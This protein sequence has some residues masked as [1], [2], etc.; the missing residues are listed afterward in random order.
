MVKKLFASFQCLQLVYLYIIF[1]YIL[2]VLFTQQPMPQQRYEFYRVFP[3]PQARVATF[4]VAT[5][6]LR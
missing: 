1:W 5:L 4:L 2:M 3:P 6:T